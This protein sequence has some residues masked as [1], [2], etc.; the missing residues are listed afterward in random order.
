VC[1][2]F[3]GGIGYTELANMPLDEFFKVV[4]CATEISRKR[5][6]EAARVK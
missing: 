5:E 6:A 1:A 3:E 4:E 2:F